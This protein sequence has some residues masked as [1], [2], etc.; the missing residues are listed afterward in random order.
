M[1]DVGFLLKFIAFSNAFFSFFYFITKMKKIVIL[2]SVF[3]LFMAMLVIVGVFYSIHIGNPLDRALIDIAGLLLPLL[4]LFMLGSG[5]RNRSYIFNT[6]KVMKFIVVFSL[7]NVM[8]M[9]SLKYVI[10]LNFNLTFGTPL[11]ALAAAICVYQR[12]WLWFFLALII[13]LLSGKRSIMIMTFLT[14]VITYFIIL[15]NSK[16]FLVIFKSL[17]AGIILATVVMSVLI[18]NWEHVVEVNPKLKKVE[19]LFSDDAD[20]YQKS[21]G[22]VDEIVQVTELYSWNYMEIVFGLG[23]GSSY[24]IFFDKYDI[25]KSKNNIHFSPLNIFSKFGLVFAVS[26][27]LYFLVKVLS[28]WKFLGPYVPV[29]IYCFF[30]V[31]FYT[32]T[33]Y[34]FVVDFSFWI[35]F[36]II[37][38][39]TSLTKEENHYAK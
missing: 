39:C 34:G 25:T 17:G 24:D 1:F 38:G 10:G 32:A 27:Y 23:L 18:S 21:T 22:R 13:A 29:G 33:N 28:R 15:L 14:S 36:S 12:A 37:V 2:E 26:F 6:S 3:I 20:M 19:Y 4:C 35:L 31:F 5:F 8:F 16:N 30:Y 11:I 9:F 7:L